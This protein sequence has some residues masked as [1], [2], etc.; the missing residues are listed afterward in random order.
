[1][2]K[3]L[4][5]LPLIPTLLLL[6]SCAHHFTVASKL[7]DISTGM[8]KAK[9]LSLMGDPDRTTNNNNAEDLIYLL[10]DSVLDT[11][12]PETYVIHLVK[13][14]VDRLGTQKEMIQIESGNNRVDKTPK[15]DLFTEISKLDELK[16]KKL[17]TDKEYTTRKEALFDGI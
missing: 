10:I 3:P 16:R 4:S 8:T 12:L 7:D 14:V 5:I 2:R 1:M 15:V 9:V 6:S 17:I 11:T 13:G